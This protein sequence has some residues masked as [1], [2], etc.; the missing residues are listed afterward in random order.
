[1]HSIFGHSSKDWLLEASFL[2]LVKFFTSYWAVFGTE[3][4]SYTGHDRRKSKWVK[5]CDYGGQVIGC[6]LPIQ[7]SK[8]LD[9]NGFANWLSDTENHQP[10][11]R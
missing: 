6:P 1:M 8:V 3:H 7:R 10:I 9:T 4:I 5:C 2:Y 11:E